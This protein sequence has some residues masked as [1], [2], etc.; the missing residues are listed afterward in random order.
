MSKQDRLATQVN[1]LLQDRRV[2]AGLLSEVWNAIENG[3]LNDRD[4]F[5]NLRQRVRQTLLDC[6]LY[7]EVKT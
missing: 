3:D 5:S 7:E 4:K 2:M 1:V 6:G